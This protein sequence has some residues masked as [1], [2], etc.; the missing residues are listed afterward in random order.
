[1]SIVP[2]TVYVC[3]TSLSC[4]HGHQ[5]LWMAGTEIIVDCELPVCVESKTRY[6]AKIPCP[7]TY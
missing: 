4:D 7:L 3:I 1:M 6:S 2:E 5:N